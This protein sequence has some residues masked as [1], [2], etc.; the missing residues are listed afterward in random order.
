MYTYTP[1]RHLFPL[2][3]VDAYFLR[4][5]NN[6]YVINKHQPSFN[7][8]QKN[9][10]EVLKEH[11]GTESFSHYYFNKDTIQYH[12]SS[13]PAHT[14]KDSRIHIYSSESEQVTFSSKRH[15]CDILIGSTDQSSA[16]KLPEAGKQR[17]EA[18]TSYRRQYPPI[19]TLGPMVWWVDRYFKTRRSIFSFIPAVRNIL[20]KDCFLRVST[21]PTYARGTRRK[22]RRMSRQAWWL[23]Q[24]LILFK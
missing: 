1:K 9:M 5:F 21:I 11:D 20:V 3:Y 4:F 8:Q 6:S 17:G 10:K 7:Y 13:H 22:V 14:W 15:R 2:Q 19:K 12:F 24:G 23:S 16:N 18:A